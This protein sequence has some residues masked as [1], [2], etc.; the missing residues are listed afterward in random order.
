MTLVKKSI[1]VTDW[2][3]QWIRRQVDSGEYGNVSGQRRPLF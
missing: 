2:Q 1:T 3:E